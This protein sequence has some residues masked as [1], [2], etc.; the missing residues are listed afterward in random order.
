[1]RLLVVS[2][3]FPE[4]AGGIETVSAELVA[5][6]RAAGHRVRWMAAATRRTPHEESADDIQLPSWN[7][8][9]ERLGFPYPLTAPWSWPRLA[10]EVRSSEV[11]HLQDSLY[12]A[13]VLAYLVAR[14]LRRPVLV[15]QHIAGVPYRNA[16]VRAVQTVAYQTLARMILRGADRVVFISPEV[17]RQLAPLGPFRHRAEVI[18]NGLDLGA[19]AAKDA[20][21]REQARIALGVAP[22]AKCLLFV[23]RF[24]E[25]KGIALL[26]EVVPARP[27][28]T[29]LLVGRAGDADPT[30]WGFPNL[31]ILPPMD[32]GAL[33]AV[34][35]AADLLVL[36]S[37]GEGFPVVVQEAMAC[38]TPAVV[39]PQT[40]AAVPDAR[41]VLFVSE[42][43]PSALITEI[44]HALAVVTA[45][46]SDMPLRVAA[47]AR[48][49]WAIETSLNRYQRLLEQL[50]GSSSRAH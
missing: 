36:P 4:H 19:F 14:R 38:G 34:Y 40:A 9:E 33:A 37:V 12:L 43:A 11:I 26:R 35:R 3:Y 7:I 50:R 45:D 20:A 16:L 47:Y 21:S 17:Q 8:T 39:T 46:Q 27:D 41:S 48:E 23:G 49:H 30:T 6:Y 32:R 2:N 28:W 1:V 15:T 24:V 42:R 44:E 29:W 22:D 13:N 5:A 31:R 18:P 25:K 10:H